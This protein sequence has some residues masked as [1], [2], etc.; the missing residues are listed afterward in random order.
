MTATVTEL[1]LP[2]LDIADPELHGERWHAAIAGLMDGGGW[3]ARSPLA[4]IVL[5][6]EAG[7]H[8]LRTKAAIFPGRLIAQL[9]GISDGPLHEQIEGNIINATATST[10][11]CA[12][13]ST[14]R[15]PRARS[16]ATG[17]RCASSSPTC[18]SRSPRPGAATSSRRCA[19]RTRRARSPR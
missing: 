17:R 15:S 5:D 3:L 16:S 11:A 1:D 10:G 12:R 4:T 13:S 2:E 19:S 7:E 9:F 14:R 8:F 18:G 6:R